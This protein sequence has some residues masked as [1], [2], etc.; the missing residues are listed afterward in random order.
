MV[1]RKI[2]G[3]GEEIPKEEH[4]VEVGTFE[5]EA[6]R[7]SIKVDKLDDFSD[8]DRILRTLREGNIVFLKIKGL[9][10]KDLGE[11]KRAVEKLKK[12]IVANNGDIA[13]I[14]QDWLILTPELVAV[15]RE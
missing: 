11:L 15:R 8:T 4:Y 1:L 2:F 10:E 3:S 12:A 5:E 6:R 7:L 13:G 14:E 9:R